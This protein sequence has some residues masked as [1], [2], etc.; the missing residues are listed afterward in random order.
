MM[1]DGS[2]GSLLAR[3]TCERGW[4]ECRFALNALS[5]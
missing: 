2:S 4:G 1:D 5:G 3:M